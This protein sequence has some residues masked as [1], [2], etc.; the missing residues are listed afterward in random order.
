MYKSGSSTILLLRNTVVP[1]EIQACQFHLGEN[2][3]LI[4][5]FHQ[6]SDPLLHLEFFRTVVYQLGFFW[7]S[8]EFFE[9]VLQVFPSTVN[10]QQDKH[11]LNQQFQFHILRRNNLHHSRIFK[12]F[13][14]LHGSFHLRLFRKYHP[15]VQAYQTIFHFF[16]LVFFLVLS[17]SPFYKKEGDSP[18]TFI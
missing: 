10:V 6:E 18:A 17:W 2:F 14:W 8:D 13:C 1:V 3:R 9:K 5:Q 7:M 16:F 12:R 15:L 4:S 11:A